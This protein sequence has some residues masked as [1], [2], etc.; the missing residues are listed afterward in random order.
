MTKSGKTLI[1]LI[2]T[3]LIK[4]VGSYL[5]NFDPLTYFSGFVGIV[6]DLSIWILLCYIILWGINKV[7]ETKEGE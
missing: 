2:L 4:S 1:T 7:V 5:T 6:I 3:Y